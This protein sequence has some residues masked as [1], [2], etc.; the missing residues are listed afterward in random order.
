[1]HFR[2]TFF[3]SSQCI[4]NK[5]ASF[6]CYTQSSMPT[7]SQIRAWPHFTLFT[8]AIC[9]DPRQTP[10]QDRR[11]ARLPRRPR[12]A[13]RARRQVGGLH[14]QS[15]DVAADKSDT[16]VWMASWDGKQQVRITSSTE[17]ENAPR[18]SPDG[19]YLSFLSG[20]PRQ[21]ARHAGLAARPHRRRSAAVHRCQGPHLVL[22]LVAR[23]Q[24]ASAGDG[25]SRS[26]RARRPTAGRRRRPRRAARMRPRPSRSSSTATSSSRTWSAISRRA[27]PACTCMTWP[28]RRPRR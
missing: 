16:D 10:D 24:E 27:R 9:P 13:N 22:R 8:V 19:R 14:C 12:R 21:S 23:F 17:A 25:R 28:P 11:H 1:M 15:V 3:N 6:V 20:R 26:R 18:W 7:V 4:C 2:T 5:F